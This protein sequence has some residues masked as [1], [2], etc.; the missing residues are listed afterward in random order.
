MI[1]YLQG[2]QNRAL[3]RKRSSSRVKASKITSGSRSNDS[4]SVPS[5]KHGGTRVFSAII[6]II[7]ISRSAAFSWPI[8]DPGIFLV[9]NQV[10][11]FQGN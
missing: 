8:W 6:D 11:R 10:D 2:K 5:S 1:K 9:D 4:V 7:Y 3:K